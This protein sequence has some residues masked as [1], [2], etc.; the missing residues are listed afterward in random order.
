MNAQPAAGADYGHRL[1][2]LDARPPQYLVRR[3]QRIGNDADLGRTP[4]VVQRFR[5][6]DEDMRRQLDVL[7]VSAVAI[8]PDIAAAARAQRLQL[9]EAPAAAAAVEVEVRRHRIAGAKPRYAGAYLDNLGADLVA[10]DTR[11]RDLPPSGLGMLNGQAGAAGEHAC[12]SLASA[13]NRVRQLHQL[14]RRVGFSQQH[15]LHGAFPRGSD[16]MRLGA[17]LL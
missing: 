12:D 13:R 16:R 14:K 6:L 11:K 17:A 15:C 3:R 10:D 1:A 9:S 4:L 2:G 7:G 8:Q 5:Q